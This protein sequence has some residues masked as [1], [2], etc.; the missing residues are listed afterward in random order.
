MADL[1]VE[2]S[3]RIATVTLNRPPVNALTPSLFENIAEVFQNV[4]ASFDAN[5]MIL[6]GSGVRA[7]CA[8]LDLNEN[9]AATEE[10]DSK[11]RNAY[12]A[13]RLCS[14]PVIAAVNGP[15][16]G[17]GS[18]LAAACDIRIAADRAT[19][20]L[21]EINVGRCGG[22]AHHARLMPQGTLRRM[23]FTGVPISAQEAW[24]IG[25]VDQVVSADQLLAVAG[26][27]AAVIAAKSPL[28]LRCAKKALSEIEGTDADRGYAL[29][30][31]HSAELLGTEDAQEAKRALIEKRPPVFVGR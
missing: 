27:L 21:P 7:F 5:C 20:G 8:G 11:R 24:R 30:Q 3:N 26:A 6:T 13:V 15:A 31:A 23:V 16:L 19:F 2:T 10:E 14:V 1:S 25:F 12:S 28:G 18:I 17:A 4:T 22:A 9:F 29:E